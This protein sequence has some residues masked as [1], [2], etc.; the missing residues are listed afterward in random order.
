MP[1]QGKRQEFLW[2]PNDYSSSTLARYDQEAEH[3][4]RA[5]NNAQSKQN[6]GDPFASDGIFNIIGLSLA[7]CINVLTMLIIVITNTL[8]WVF[9]EYKNYK[10][11]KQ[12][13]PHNIVIQ[14]VVP[15][16]YSVNKI[17]KILQ[18]RPTVFKSQ[19]HKLFKKAAKNVVI[20]QKIS[21]SELMYEL[22]VDFS[23]VSKLID[24]LYEAGIISGL[25]SYGKRK[26]L[27][28]NTD[29]LELL[30][31]LERDYEL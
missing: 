30:F 27:I 4:T 10:I 6:I 26:V 29:A 22:K 18:N 16:Q 13:R 3:W 25:I 2:R 20:R 11:N 19:R 21:I 23:T 24:E 12:N 5:F 14:P 31:K 28:N 17:Q 15:N 1:T 7:L 9:D 8:K